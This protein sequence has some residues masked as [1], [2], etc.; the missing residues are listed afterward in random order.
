M[1]GE[2]D[3]GDRA[4]ALA[5]PLAQEPDQVVAVRARHAEV[6]HE[7]VDRRPPED[8][9]RLRDRGHRGDAGA[10]LLEHRP[11]QLEPV[12]VVVHDEDPHA[13]ERGRRAGEA[14]GRGPAGRRR[15]GRSPRPATER[16]GAGR[17]PP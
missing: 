3:G 1:R 5:R 8:V 15:L 16:R 7:D 11:R 2:R 13:R 9:E 10:G 17:R 4:A 14:L 12:Q 6:A